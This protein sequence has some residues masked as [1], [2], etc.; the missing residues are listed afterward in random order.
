MICLVNC[1]SESLLHSFG[2]F[3]ILESL[4]IGRASH[5]VADSSILLWREHDTIPLKEP[6]RAAAVSLA[7]MRV[8][9]SADEI[10][11]IALA[12]VMEKTDK[13]DYNKHRKSKTTV[14]KYSVCKL[15]KTQNRK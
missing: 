10:E 6:Y 13:L 5:M 4:L 2:V 11:H 12:K 14:V 1:L 8:Y 15:Q 7:I 3:R 9:A